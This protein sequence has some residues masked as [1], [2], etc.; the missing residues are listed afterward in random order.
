MQRLKNIACI[1]YLEWL[2]INRDK[3]LSS[4]VFLAVFLYLGLFG[5]VYCSGLLLDIPVAVVDQD[6]TPT[7]RD[8][9]QKIAANDRLDIICYPQTTREIDQL[10]QANQ[11]RAG[12]AIPENFE[13]DIQSG[14]PV[15]VSTV[16]DGSNLIYTYN[17]R[18]AVIDINR[19]LG[20]EI[21]ARTLVGTGMEPT[22]VENLLRSVEFVSESRYNPT[23]NYCYFLYL[24][25]VVIAVQQTC[26]LGEGLTLAR[27]KE[28]NTWVQFALSP[29]SNAEI[30]LG[31]V[32]PYYLILLANA[33]LVLTGAYLFLRLPMHG[34]IFLLWL[35]F[36]V[37]ALA[38]VSLGYWISSYCNDVTQ[39]TMII[40]LFNVPM[41]LCSG[42][43]WPTASM[44][45]ILKYL[46]Y[47]FPATWLMHAARAITMKAGGWDIVGCDILILSIM[48]LFFVSG[49]IFSTRRLRRKVSPGNKNVP[50]S[51]PGPGSTA[52]TVT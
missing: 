32:L 40:C 46:G 19:S 31:K 24:M 11:V 9:I 10:L 30:F 8:V 2:S 26:L 28:L 23:F 1:A 4:V 37:F 6:H 48:A 42:F 45:P 38:I 3:F 20:A 35:V 14:Q 13:K 49:A 17:L 52:G 18:K 25:L 27:E 33:G 51:S 44:A 50:T 15:R 21:M 12:I 7:S 5:F 16:A 41:V 39:A 34:S 29:M 36:A 47:L 43:T 22:R